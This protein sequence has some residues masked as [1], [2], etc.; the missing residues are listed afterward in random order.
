MLYM[1]NIVAEM[2][3]FFE[4]PR[5]WEEKQWLNKGKIGK[6]GR[7]RA[8]FWVM[9]RALMEI[10]ESGRHGCC[11]RMDS[12]CHLTHTHRFG[13]GTGDKRILFWPEA[14]YAIIACF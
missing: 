5:D 3:K 14:G 13:V 12:Q 7:Q 11:I 10:K 9:E 1:C 2:E 6:K 4:D 8:D